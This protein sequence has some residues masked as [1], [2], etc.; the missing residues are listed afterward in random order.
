M[1]G[2]SKGRTASRGSQYARDTP[3][4]VCRS[5][6]GRL[7][8]ASYS[9]LKFEHRL[10]TTFSVVTDSRFYFH[11]FC[12]KSLFFPVL[13]LPTD[14]NE[15]P[16]MLLL[17]VLLLLLLLFYFSLCL[18]CPSRTCIPGGRPRRLWKAWFPLSDCGPG[19]HGAPC[20]ILPHAR[21]SA[22]HYHTRAETPHRMDP[23]Q[24]SVSNYSCEQTQLVLTP[25]FCVAL[26]EACRGLLA[27]LRFPLQKTEFRL[28]ISIYF[29]RLWSFPQVD[30][31]LGKERVIAVKAIDSSTRKCHRFTI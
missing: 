12:N 7:Q 19:Q 16:R 17:L 15:R 4:A 30:N 5:K 22:S 2:E 11:L 26:Q 18:L 3:T 8:L 21:P 27:T 23:V 9:T 29:W 31:G 1:H 6:E 28:C 24:T 13:P 14:Q 20:G 10:P 25:A